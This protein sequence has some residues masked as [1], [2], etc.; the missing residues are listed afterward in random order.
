MCSIDFPWCL[1]SY[2]DQMNML[3]EALQAQR[4][5]QEIRGKAQAKVNLKKNFLRRIHKLDLWLP[6]KWTCFCNIFSSRNISILNSIVQI[7]FRR[8]LFKC[9]FIMKY[10]SVGKIF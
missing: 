2:K 7:C 5:E 1:Y 6:K 3:A 8:L 4:E 9:Q 10:C